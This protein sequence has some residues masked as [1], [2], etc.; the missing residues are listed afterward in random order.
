MRF[1]TDAYAFCNGCL[2]VYEVPITREW[3]F[4]IL[5]TSD[6]V[7]SLRT[8]NDQARVTDFSAFDGCAESRGSYFLHCYL[9]CAKGSMQARW[10]T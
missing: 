2:S 1:V 6:L 8:I 9:L 5:F 3:S 4:T 7:F 10:R